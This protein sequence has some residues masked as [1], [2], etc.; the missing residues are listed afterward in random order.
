MTNSQAARQATGTSAKALSGKAGARLLI[1]SQDIAPVVLVRE[2]TALSDACLRELESLD[3]NALKA[4]HRLSR[5]VTHSAHKRRMRP[6]LS[7]SADGTRV[8][9]GRPPAMVLCLH[10]RVVGDEGIF[11]PASPALVSSSEMVSPEICRHIARSVRNE[12]HP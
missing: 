2:P 1:R 10:S 4:T 8:L 6:G 3:L 5:R 7:V 9:D 11:L 12:V